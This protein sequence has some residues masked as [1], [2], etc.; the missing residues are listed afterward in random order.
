MTRLAGRARSAAA[1]LLGSTGAAVTELRGA[2]ARLRAALPLSRRIG[3]VAL[4]GGSGTT[5]V[6]ASLASLL[7]RRR[8]GMVLGVDASGGALG[9]LR[10]TVPDGA[11]EASQ[12]GQG[13]QADQ[14][15]EA[16]AAR[17]RTARTAADAR[18]GLVT[19]ASGLRLLDLSGPGREAAATSTW[20]AAVGPVARFF[21]LV[22]TDWGVR[23][24]DDELAEIAASSHVLVVVARAER[25][26]ATAAAE[27]L[28]ALAAPPAG[29]RSLLVLVDVAR[30]PERV[31]AGLQRALGR[32]VLLLPH[33]PE[34]SRTA[35]PTS[36]RFSG[37]TRNAHLRLAVAVVDDA[38]ASQAPAPGR[39]RGADGLPAAAPAAPQTAPP[40]VP[41]TLTTAVPT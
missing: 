26:A 6:V 7:A 5:S 10:Q 29:P 25:H 40:A 1:M 3:V 14:A 32:P 4:G 28:A 34:R 22:L 21:D 37:R 13:H 30:T 2:D 18:A 8:S 39:R 36:R 11:G 24:A 12:A 9:L 35:T 15:T 27:A 19:T 31:G 23:P 17:R 41:P 38:V 33:E 20:G 16:A